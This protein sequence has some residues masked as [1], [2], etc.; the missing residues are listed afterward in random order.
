MILGGWINDRFG[1]RAIIPAGG[2]VMGIGFC[3]AARAATPL[4][5]I[6][7]YG[8]GFGL[9]LGFVY[10][11][12][13]NTTLKLFPDHRGLAGVIATAVYGLSS[14]TIPPVAH[15]LALKPRSSRWAA[16]LWS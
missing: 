6:L 12:S 5:L 2:L 10:G 8:L 16:S 1:P 14:V 11:S 4:E 3:L 9:G 13:I 15:A 7:G